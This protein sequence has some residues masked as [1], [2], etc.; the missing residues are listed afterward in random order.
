[1]RIINPLAI[2]GYT[3]KVAMGA[4]LIVIQD[5]AN[6]KGVDLPGGANAAKVV[7]ITMAAAA[8]GAQVDVCIAGFFDVV[9][10]ST[11]DIAFQ[12]G[13]V[14]KD[15]TGVGIKAAAVA[16][17]TY[18]IVGYAWEVSTDDNLGNLIS[19]RLQQGAI[20]LAAS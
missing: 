9:V 12:D 18:N 4:N 8:A 6:S 5:S 17:T 20:V 13:I 14:T 1:M 3:A 7:G 19:V 2:A 16:N 10:D 15:T 11:T